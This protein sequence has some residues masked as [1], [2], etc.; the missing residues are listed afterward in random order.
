MGYREV[1]WSLPRDLQQVIARK[2]INDG[3]YCKLPSM[4]WMFVPLTQYHGGGAAATIEPLCDHLDHYR[5]MLYNN[6]LSGV[7]A[8][9]RGFRIYDTD[10][11]RIMVKDAV[12]LYKK[13]R[14]I[15]ESPAVHIRRADG[16]DYDGFIHCNNELETKGFA[17]FF[18]PLNIEIIRK[19]DIPV[20][21][22][23]LNDT[24]IIS[25][26]DKSE[27]AEKYEISRD[28]YVTVEVMIPAKDFVWYTVK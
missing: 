25:K 5:I 13:Y 9:Y 6:I 11:T 26:F 10:D 27:N 2:N 4:G 8:A 23:G 20:Y 28:Y 3:T 14:D 22:T 12:A 15:L 17:V 1:N 16:R 24:A 19:I 21:Y 7:Q 18:N